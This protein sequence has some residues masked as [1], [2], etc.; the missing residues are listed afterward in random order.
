MT[1]PETSGISAVMAARLAH[2]L[3][4]P[5]GVVLGSLQQV[6]RA[7]DSAVGPQEKALLEL[8][9]RSVR[10][11]ERLAVRLDALAE[12]QSS[13]GLDPEAG[14]PTQLGELLERAIATARLAA[15]RSRIDVVLQQPESTEVRAGVS[16]AVAVAVEEVVHNAIRHARRLVEV[17]VNAGPDGSTDVLVE[18]DGRGIAEE[19][20]DA[21]FRPPTGSGSGLGLGTWIAK[22]ALAPAGGDVFVASTESTG[23]QVTVRFA[24]D[25]SA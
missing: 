13:D 16:R 7:P 22:K 8:A 5:L 23:T 9:L 18:D 17:R 14:Q 6:T 20:R 24:A 10:R 21:M 4:S 1:K 19:R 25:R 2:E 12:V 15:G 11:V 3:R